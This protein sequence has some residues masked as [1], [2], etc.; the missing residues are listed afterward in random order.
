MSRDV[1]EYDTSE[2]LEML[3]EMAADAEAYPFVSRYEVREEL[4]KRIRKPYKRA[5]TN[6]Q[7]PLWVYE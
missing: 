5:Y 3:I 7:T 4:N 1:Q 2:L 6:D